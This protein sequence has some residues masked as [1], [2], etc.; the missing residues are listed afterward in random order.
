LSKRFYHILL[1]VFCALFLSACAATSAY[2]PPTIRVTGI[3]PLEMSLFE[4]QYRLMM[5]IQNPNNKTLKITGMRYKLILNGEIF[6]RGV[7]NH[8]Y[9]LPALGEKNVEMSVSTGAL[10]WLNQIKALQGQNEALAYDLIGTFYL[11]GPLGRSLDFRNQ[12][13]IGAP[14]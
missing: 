4:Q 8:Q 10:E 5:R 7:S 12:G 13:S 2:E 1:T 11:D 14:R 3:T 9:D 6:A